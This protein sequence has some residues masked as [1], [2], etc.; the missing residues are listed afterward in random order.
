M[1]SPTD[2]T[3]THPQSQET[4]CLTK[5]PNNGTQIQ[6]LTPDEHYPTGNP[7]LLIHEALTQLSKFTESLLNIKPLI[8]KCVHPDN[9]VFQH[10]IRNWYLYIAEIPASTT[11]VDIENAL[12]LSSEIPI[13]LSIIKKNIQLDVF[14]KIICTKQQALKLLK[15]KLSLMGKEHEIKFATGP[16]WIKQTKWDEQQRHSHWS[17]NKDTKITRKA[18]N[19]RSSNNPIQQKIQTYIWNRHRQWRLNLKAQKPQRKKHHSIW[20]TI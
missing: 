5:I 15:S 13:S 11:I 17:K 10:N 6:N 14:L 2:N 8:E 4:S 12:M 18:E 16:K 3:Q 20:H 9:K 7:A 19:H 1:P